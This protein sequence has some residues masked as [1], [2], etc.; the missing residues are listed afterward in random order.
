[1]LKWFTLSYECDWALLMAKFGSKWHLENREI[2]QN[3]SL[4]SE[5]PPDKVNFFNV[6]LH[7]LLNQGGATLLKLISLR[8]LSQL[9]R[10]E[11]TSEFHD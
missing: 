5:Y 6:K 8:Y 9:S 10:K 4:K 11:G 2:Y 1:M 3:K 7:S